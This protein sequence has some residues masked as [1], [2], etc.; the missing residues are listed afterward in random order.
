MAGTVALILAGGRGTRLGGEIPK[1]YLEVGGIPVLRR[2]LEAFVTHPRIDAVGA[3]IHRDDAALYAAAADGLELMDPVFGGALRRESSHNGLMYIKNINPEKVLVH[4]AARPFVD[5][6][7]IGR[8]LDALDETPAAIATTRIR[9][10]DSMVKPPLWVRTGPARP[11]N[12]LSAAKCPG[13]FHA[14]R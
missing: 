12:D 2:S 4:D 7:T 5:A 9:R 8:V 6:A 10:V 11:M 14:K 1:Q 13:F 3:V